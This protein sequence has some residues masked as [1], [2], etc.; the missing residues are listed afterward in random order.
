MPIFGDGTQTR[1]FSYIDDVARVIARS[2]LLESAYNRV[3]NVGSDEHFTV[4]QL[5]ETVSDVMG[6]ERNIRFLRARD[7]VPHAFSSHERCRATF[8]DCLTNVD[9][10]TGLQRMA[11]WA[12]QRGPMTPSEFGAIEVRIN[13]P[14]GW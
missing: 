7:E 13:L 4:L 1:A 14:E 11:E 5:A 3:F 8:V 6:V 12:R 10:R 9:L 2:G